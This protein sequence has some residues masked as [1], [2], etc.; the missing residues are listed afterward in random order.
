MHDEEK[1]LWFMVAV[2]F[3][4]SLFKFISY[5]LLSLSVT[6]TNTICHPLPLIVAHCQ[7]PAFPIHCLEFSRFGFSI[8][9]FLS[10][11]RRQIRAVQAGHR[12]VPFEA[13]ERQQDRVLD[14][15]SSS[16]QIEALEQFD[17][18]S[19]DLRNRIVLEGKGLVLLDLHALDKRP[20]VLQRQQLRA[21]NVVTVGDQQVDQCDASIVD[22]LE[23]IEFGSVKRVLK[24]KRL[25]GWSFIERNCFVFPEDF[26]MN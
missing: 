6:I 26:S 17:L 13:V 7:K 24:G 12:G 19:V 5:Q 25:G 4:S 3:Y 15:S 22:H 1:T 2:Q 11:K 9:H 8:A 21:E 10:I 18:S 23:L 16:V 14:R 20:E